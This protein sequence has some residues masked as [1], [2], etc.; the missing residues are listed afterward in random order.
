MTRSAPLSRVSALFV[1]ISNGVSM[2]AVID[3]GGKQR[4]VQVG[5]VV[6]VE[7]IAGEVEVVLEAVDEIVRGGCD[8]HEVG[9]VPRA[10]QCDRR[11]VEDQVDVCRDERLPVTAFLGLLDDAH[12]RRVTFGERLLVG[13]IGSSSRRGHERCERDGSHEQISADVAHPAHSP[14]TRG[15]STLNRPRDL[16]SA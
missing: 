4:R 5:D 8:L 3:I 2:Y 14:L 7:R 10:A 13:V 11:L 16:A 12:D 9:A 15:R 6:R 1:V